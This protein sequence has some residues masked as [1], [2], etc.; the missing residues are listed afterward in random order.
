MNFDTTPLETLDVRLIQT[1]LE[2]L[3][4]NCDGDLERYLDQVG[5]TND[6]EEVIRITLLLIALRFS[7]NSYRAVC[8]LFADTDDHPRRLN[9][10]VVVAPP[11]IR[12]LIDLWC[13]LIYILDDF[14]SR[15]GE[16]QNCAWLEVSDHIKRMRERYGADSKRQQWFESME[17]LR[18]M[19]EKGVPKHLKS[20]PSKIAYWPTPGR[21]WKE[22]RTKSH[23][24]LK[25]LHDWLYND[26]SAEAHLKPGGLLAAGSFL[27]KDR[28]SEEIRRQIE[29]NTFHEYKARRFCLTIVPLLGII[30][31]IEMF[32][33]F[34]NKEQAAKVWSLLAAY[35]PDAKDIYEMRYQVPL[36]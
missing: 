11:I 22:E 9:E 16:F 17:E 33:N 24:F 3:I 4:R 30:S 7:I 12:Q 14:A 19:L 18:V 28:A 36:G 21:L 26:I 29:T 31:E 8:F 20:E 13:S 10:F 25:Y 27:L 32:G 1:P 34:K 2:G 35:S 6:R 15:V 5:Q 23:S